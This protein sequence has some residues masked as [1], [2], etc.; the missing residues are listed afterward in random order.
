MVRAHGLEMQ[1]IT[2]EEQP[3][4]HHPQKGAGPVAPPEAEEAVAG[5]VTVEV[6]VMTTVMKRSRTA[7]I[8]D[9]CRQ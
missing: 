6:V 4:E 9:A 7:K 5:Q 2:S 3:E 8:Q 1:G